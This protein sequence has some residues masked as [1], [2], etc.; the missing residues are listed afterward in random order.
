M[1]SNSGAPGWAGSA[2]EG[3]QSRAPVRAW[4]FLGILLG[5]LA[6]A[7]LPAQVT[8]LT[9]RVLDEATG[10][11]VAGAV[12]SLVGLDR[13]ALSDAHGIFHLGAVAPGSYTLRV[14]HLAYGEHEDP[15]RVAGSR[16]VA[17]RIALSP[18]AL[19]LE[20]VVVEA[21]SAESR[22]ARGRGT[23]RNV[24]TR[25][26]IESSLGTA[27]HLGQVLRQ[28][29]SGV[30]I[31]QDQNRPGTAICVEFRIP[32]SIQDPFSCKSP[33][34]FVDGARVADPQ[35]LWTTMPVENVESM[36]LLPGA[37]AGV[38]YGTDSNY[39][40]LLIETRSGLRPDAGPRRSATYDWALER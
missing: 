14:V 15:L 3:G 40:V 11:P 5:F 35:V 9:G 34:V 6:A 20:P 30:R 4:A 1:M 16:R 18:T 19:V 13:S 7:D 36:E 2:V 12:I 33:T 27:R 37:E 32:R 28:H 26:E 39:G 25:A 23:R 24:V 21:R 10:E 38:L 29:V 31:K 22:D 17:L 8:D